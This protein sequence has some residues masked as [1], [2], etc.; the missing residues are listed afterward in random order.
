MSVGESSRLCI[1]Q[2]F[3]VQIDP[4]YVFFGQTLH[5]GNRSKP[6][7]HRGSPYLLS[8]EFM[9]ERSVSES[10]HLATPYLET[11]Y[12][13]DV[14]ERFLRCSN[15]IVLVLCFFVKTTL[16]IAQTCP[17][18]WSVFSTLFH[19]WLFISILTLCALPPLVY[20]LNIMSHSRN[21]FWLRTV[22]DRLLCIFLIFMDLRWSQ[23][24]T[25]SNRTES[26]FDGHFDG[27]WSRLQTVWR[28]AS[29]VLNR[30]TNRWPVV[31]HFFEASFMCFHD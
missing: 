22:V 15:A 7:Q 20:F 11:I 17:H 28:K 1:F 30:L 3:G 23:Q 29:D 4:H 31:V 8:A 14:L 25:A 27:Q 19:L 18:M 21:P 10:D 9:G 2:F 26:G 24:T 16:V 12:F 5:R 13:A 6:D